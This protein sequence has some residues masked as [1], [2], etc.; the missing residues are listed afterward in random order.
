[1]IGEEFRVNLDPIF[2]DKLKCVG[3]KLKLKKAYGTDE[4]LGELW[5]VIVEDDA[6]SFFA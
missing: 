3:R 4:I 5:R 1:M 2:A 6:Y